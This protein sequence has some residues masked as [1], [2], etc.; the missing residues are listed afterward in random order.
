MSEEVAL[1]PR[2][3]VR[4]IQQGEFRIG[5][6][7]LEKMWC[8]EGL[9]CLARLY[10]RPIAQRSARL[11]RLVKTDRGP[12]L[13]LIAAPLALI[14]LHPTRYALS[15]NTAEVSWRIESGL[16]VATTPASDGAVLRILARRERDAR[17]P[18][19]ALL[20]LTVEVEGYQPRLRGRGR[21]ACVG[22]WVYRRTQLRIHVW[23]A[24]AFM[25]SV[26]RQSGPGPDQSG[27]SSF[28][29][30]RGASGCGF[31]VRSSRKL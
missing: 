15:D 18:E 1:E 16:L 20:H 2:A 30:A 3:P 12:R 8:P 23:Q 27:Y 22:T 21:F 5:S 14:R 25:R 24:R 31:G 13:V 6:A 26:N 29:H 4:S 17:S 10:W 11:L 9:A 28:R 7:A 19:N